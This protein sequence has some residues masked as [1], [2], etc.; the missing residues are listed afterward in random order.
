MLIKDMAQEYVFNHPSNGIF[1]VLVIR[2]GKW[3][4]YF[5]T[6][7]MQ[8]ASLEETTRLYNAMSEECRLVEW[9][10]YLNDGKLVVYKV[11]KYKK[12]EQ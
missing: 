9:C 4:E 12:A 1:G 10:R 7:F 2:E 11:I 3:G 5:E 8:V 6:L